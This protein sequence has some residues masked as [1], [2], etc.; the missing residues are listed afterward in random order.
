MTRLR[1]TS[2]QELADARERG[3]ERRER[4]RCAVRTQ[5][6]LGEGDSITVTSGTAGVRPTPGNALAASRAAAIEGGLLL[7][8]N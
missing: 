3:E 6:C 4:R 8:G 7:T 5:Q 1:D 2:D